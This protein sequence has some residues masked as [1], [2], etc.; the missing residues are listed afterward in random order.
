MSHPQDRNRYLSFQK[1]K[2]GVVLFEGIHK[3]A[4]EV[5]ASHGY[6]NVTLLPKAPSRDQLREA[7]STARII[8]IRS[9]TQLTAELFDKAISPRLMAIGCFCIGTNQVDLPAAAQRGIPVFNAP[10]SNTRS[11]AELVIGEI[12]MLMRGIFPKSMGAHKDG[13]WLKSAKDS[14]EVRGKTLGIVGYGHIGSQVS[15]LAEAMGM[16]VCYF[17]TA[18]KLPL[19]NAIKTN[20]MEELLAMSDVVTL[21][22]PATPDTVDMIGAAELDAMKDG[23]HLINASRGNVV[24]IEALAERLRSGRLGGAAV[25][26][27]P[28]EPKSNDDA[29]ISPL[30]GIE[31]A[32]LTPHIGGS[33]QEAQENIGVEVANKL[34]LFSDRGSTEGSVNFP[35]VNLRPN[36]TSHRLLHIHENHPG[37]MGKINRELSQ[38][39]INVT[40][41][42][43][44]T[45]NEIGYVVIDF[46]PNVSRTDSQSVNESLREIP[47]TIRTRLLY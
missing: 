4:V 18:Q 45:T 12:I 31:T 14:Y 26:V 33:T 29:L 19:G 11:V 5:F 17:D 15:V 38:A 3:H 16:R 1:D 10:H 23:A 43:L 47:G 6:P 22:V 25:D 46:D 8:G 24:V 37:V 30:L 2:I 32:I 9:R 36:E 44:D 13:T 27:Y 42:H 35:Q 7:L 20:S 39:G 28:K 34:A 41:Q 40:G 21:H